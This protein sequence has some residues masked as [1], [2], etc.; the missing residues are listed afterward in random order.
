MR[1]IDIAIDLLSQQGHTV[2]IVHIANA[3]NKKNNYNK[4]E[5]KT[6]K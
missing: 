3:K 2:N 5:N 1:N 4:R 6:R